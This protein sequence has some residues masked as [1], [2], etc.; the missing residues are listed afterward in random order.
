MLDCWVSTRA[1]PCSCAP[2]LPWQRRCLFPRGQ[3]P[4]A[5]V[6]AA[7]GARLKGLREVHEDVE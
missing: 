5:N 1:A 4:L 3:K 7:N 2:F 6:L